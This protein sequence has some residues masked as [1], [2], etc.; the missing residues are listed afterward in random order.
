M[1]IQFETKETFN[2]PREKVYEGLLDLDSAK[3][4]MQGLVRIERLDE[5]S[6]KVGSVW[7]ET[8]KMMGIEGG[9]VLK[10]TVLEPNKIQLY[11]DGSKGTSGKGEHFYTN[12]IK[13]LGN[14]TEVTLHG[15]IKG[16]TGIAKLVSKLM[17]GTYRKIC[18]KDLDGLKNYL[19]K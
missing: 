16:M 6:I 11:V 18:A 7:K 4:W 15:E 10:V 3:H 5:G 9:E 13:E 8:R 14:A 19:E 17:T 1:S 2:V 12:S